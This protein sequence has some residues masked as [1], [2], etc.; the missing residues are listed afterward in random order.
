MEFKIGDKVTI[1]NTSYPKLFG[2]VTMAFNGQIQV[3]WD[4]GIDVA[5]TAWQVSHMPI[6]LAN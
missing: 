6:T 1:P 2:I 4:N 3:R 5:Y